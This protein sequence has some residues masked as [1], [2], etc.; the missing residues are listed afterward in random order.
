[1]DAAVDTFSSAARATNNTTLSWSHTCGGAN[2]YLL[3]AVTLPSARSV[4]GI[5]YNGVGLSLVKAQSALANTRSELWGLVAPAGGSNTIQVT[6]DSSCQFA[7]GATSFKN[8]DQV[9]P[10]GTAASNS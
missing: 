3:V 4:S 5:T 2:R 8:V 7:C 9:T 6:V 1:M 10:L